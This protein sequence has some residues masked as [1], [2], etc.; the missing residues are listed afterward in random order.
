M[1]SG[2]AAVLMTA[3]E[4]RMPTDEELSQRAVTTILR[5]CQL[6]AELIDD[7]LDISRISSGRFSLDTKPLDFAAAVRTVVESNR[8]AAEKKRITLVS[9]GLQ[10]RAIVSGDARRLQQ[11]ASNLLGNAL[12]FTPDGGRVEVALTQLGT[13]VELS[14]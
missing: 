7:L 13:L 1:I 2:W 6:Q 5:H 3:R 14:V 11:V 10:G 8:P 12:K 9:A 4:R